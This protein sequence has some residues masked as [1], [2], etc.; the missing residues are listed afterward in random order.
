MRERRRRR[1]NAT[2]FAG[3]IGP[4][5]RRKARRG[6]AYTCIRFLILRENAW[7]DT[8]TRRR[9]FRWLYACVSPDAHVYPSPL[10]SYRRIHVLTYVRIRARNTSHVCPGERIDRGAKRVRGT[11]AGPRDIGQSV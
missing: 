7:R 3:F 10:R 8:M 4:I 5:R 6:C 11:S 2:T 9:L 1:Q